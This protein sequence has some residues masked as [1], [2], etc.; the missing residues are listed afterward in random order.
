MI[1]LMYFQ[2]YISYILSNVF[3]IHLLIGQNLKFSKT[4]SKTFFY[5]L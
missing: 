2:G 3:L 5:F 1:I 4:F